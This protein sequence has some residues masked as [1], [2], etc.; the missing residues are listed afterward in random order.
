M[1]PLLPGQTV[2]VLEIPLE[3]PVST[4]SDCMDVPFTMC[5]KDRYITP[6]GATKKER[7]S[8]S[9]FIA[10]TKSKALFAH[11]KW[12]HESIARLQTGIVE[13]INTH[14]STHIKHTFKREVKTASSVTQLRSA[15]G[16]VSIVES[17]GPSP[18]R[19]AMRD[20]P[21]NR[22]VET[23]PSSIYGPCKLAN[24][25]IDS[26]DS[27]IPHR[28]SESVKHA[29]NSGDLTNH[30]LTNSSTIVNTPSEHHTGVEAR[31]FTGVPST[32]T[33]SCEGSGT[34]LARARETITATKNKDTVTTRNQTRIL[35]KQMSTERNQKPLFEE[36]WLDLEAPGRLHHVPPGFEDHGHDFSISHYSDGAASEPYL[37]RALSAYRSLRTIHRLTWKP[38]SKH[39]KTRGF[40]L[41]TS[42]HKVPKNFELSSASPSSVNRSHPTSE[43]SFNREC[44]WT[45]IPLPLSSDSASRTF[46]FLTTA[47]ASQN[48]EPY[49]PTKH[50]A[51]MPFEPSSMGAGQQ[52]S[53]AIKPVM[54][55]VAKNG[56]YNE[57]HLTLDDCPG[58]FRRVQINGTITPNKFENPFIVTKERDDEPPLSKREKQTHNRRISD[59]DEGVADCLP[60]LRQQDEVRPPETEMGGGG[61][62][63]D[64]GYLGAFIV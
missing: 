24:N 10:L 29:C 16:P 20:F 49:T 46:D 55:A 25:V 41:G 63:E 22:P 23:R 27:V 18:R 54:L 36:S 45:P 28:I 58:R 15:P 39:N 11:T 17:A 12:L 13:A 8:S 42:S 37:S 21:Q 56:F 7:P 6:K 3:S 2:N 26:G 57:F 19:A 62:M 5:P 52:L 48:P 14:S 44:L 61:L 38:K 32:T 40:P 35:R 9:N 34:P 50:G 53:N 64:L 33:Q 47:K 60:L 51:W 4:I 30:R 1:C 43:A 31:R 59:E